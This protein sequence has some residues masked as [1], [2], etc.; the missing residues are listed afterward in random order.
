MTHSGPNASYVNVVRSLWAAVERDPVLM[1]RIN[2]WLT[3]AWIIMIPISSELGWL[4]SVTY[5]SALSLWSLVTGHLSTWQAA[6]LEVVQQEQIE[7]EQQEPVETRVVN[8]IV[9]KTEIARS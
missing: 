9:D 3:V 7:K 1:R 4:T 2:G 5:V 6:R 8:E